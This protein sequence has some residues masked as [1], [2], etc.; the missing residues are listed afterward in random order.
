MD[1]L[2]QRRGEQGFLAVKICVESA[3]RIARGCG[4]FFKLRGFE[5]IAREYLF[6][7]V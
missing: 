7:S 4:D 5:T 1:L 3:A 6:R 2:F